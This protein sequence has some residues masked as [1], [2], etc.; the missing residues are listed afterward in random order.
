MVKGKGILAFG[1]LVIVFIIAKTCLMQNRRG[2]SSR[3]IR[4]ERNTL[5]K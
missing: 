1:I 2:M 5:R 4:R 3:Q